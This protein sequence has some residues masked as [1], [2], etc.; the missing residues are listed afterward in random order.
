[1]A[2]KMNGADV[3]QQLKEKVQCLSLDKVEE[4]TVE[5]GRGSYGTVYEVFVDGKKCA[6]KKLHD[7]LVNGVP[8]SKNRVVLLHIMHILWL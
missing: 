5:I 1:M 4:T 7:I 8:V 2:E 3:V 6:G